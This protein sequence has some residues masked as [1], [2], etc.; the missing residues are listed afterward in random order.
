MATRPQLI[1]LQTERAEP[2]DDFET[3]LIRQRG[4]SPRTIFGD[5]MLDLPALNVRDVVAFSEHL[6]SLA[7]V[8]TC[9]GDGILF[10]VNAFET[11]LV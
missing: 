1:P 8:S 9:S 11:N 3:Y 5:N 10:R 2:L 6:L 7:P 4:L